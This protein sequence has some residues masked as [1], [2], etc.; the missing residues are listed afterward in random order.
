MTFRI[1]NAALLSLLLV[2]SGCARSGTSGN[3][4]AA[5]V[6]TW[7]PATCPSDQVNFLVLG[8]WGDGGKRQ[9]QV[10]AAFADYAGASSTPF[11]AVLTTGDNFYINFHKGATDPYWQNLF[12]EMYNATRLNFPFYA[13]L[14]NHDYDHRIDRV[15]F[16]YAARNPHSRFKL[17]ANWYRMEFPAQQ[18]IVTVLMLDSNHERLSKEQWAAQRKWMAAELARPRTSRWLIVV[19]HHPLF[20]N[21]DH[22]DDRRLQQEWGPL[23]RQHGV[24]FYFCGHDHAMQHLRPA[25][26]TTDF[27]LSGGGG[28]SRHPMRRADRGPFS[29]SIYGFAH[30]RF[31]ASAAEIGLID[32]LTGQL[33]HQFVRGTDGQTTIVQTTPSDKAVAASAAK[34]NTPAHRVIKAEG[35]DYKQM[36]SILSFTS[37]YRPAFDKAAEEDDRSAALKALPL[38]QLQ[39][40]AAYTLYSS[41]IDTFKPVSLSDEQKQQAFAACAALAS[42]ST[43]GS[44]VDKDPY[45]KPDETTRARAISVIHDQIL[46]TVQRK[47]LAED[48]GKD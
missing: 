21:G 33:V 25:D 36:A 13:T 48:A 19:A 28:R 10:A 17:P 4:P 37:E 9:K 3:G 7:T 41:V 15:Q 2:I 42:L 23:F 45:L 12:E 1:A 38:G 18:P 29:K 16:E 39:R 8:D 44:S 31:T 43:D 35:D 26:W 32:G 24:D 40:W 46:S 30:A 20:S 47:K 27:V 6:A 34:V 22:G 11:N 5:F 14:G